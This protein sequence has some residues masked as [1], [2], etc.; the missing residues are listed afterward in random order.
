MEDKHQLLE[1]R[2]NGTEVF[3]SGGNTLAV[4]KA[5][6]PILRQGQFYFEVCVE[7]TGQNSI[8]SV[9]ICTMS[10]P[11]NRHPGWNLNSIGYH[12]DDGFIYRDG[13]AAFRPKKVFKQG[14]LVGVLLDFTKS[15][16]TFSRNKEDVQMIQFQPHQMNQ[17]FYP[18]IGFR[19]SGAVV[20][21]TT[22]VATYVCL[23]KSKK[24]IVSSFE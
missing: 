5:D 24:T 4:V 16:L 19:S 6:R 23:Q 1:V 21:L 10:H 18:S 7:N 8:I 12:G 22:P 2:K 9:G 13:K 20:R 15:T 11:L 14:F 17:D 3:Y